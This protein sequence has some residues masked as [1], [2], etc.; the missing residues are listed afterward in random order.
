[1][2]RR[3]IAMIESALLLKN[4]VFSKINIEAD[5][6]PRVG[7]VGEFNVHVATSVLGHHGDPTSFVVKLDVTISPKEDNNGFPYRMEIS[8]FGE[9]KHTSQ[10]KLAPGIFHVNAKS[11]VFGAIRELITNMSARMTKGPFLLPLVS[12][13]DEATLTDKPLRKPAKKQK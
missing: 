11:I 12:F 4:I 9:F 6:K 5:D 3:V 10:I 7:K 8:A 13:Q 1:M 2:E